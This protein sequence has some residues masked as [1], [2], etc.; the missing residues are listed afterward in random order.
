MGKI[1]CFGVSTLDTLVPISHADWVAKNFPS[2]TTGLSSQQIVGGD[3]T[4][5]A[6]V[7]AGL[8]MPVKH[9][10]IVGDDSSGRIIQQHL[11]Q[12]AGLESHLLVDNEGDSVSP[13]IYVR[14]GTGDRHIQKKP[15]KLTVSPDQ[16]DMSIL[17]D[18]S[19]LYLDG[20]YCE[21]AL[22]LAT[23]AKARGILVVVEEDTFGRQ[24][25]KELIALA[26]IVFVS[27]DFLIK[28]KAWLDE[29]LEA[30]G[31]E[32]SGHPVASELAALANV[33][34]A[35]QAIFTTLGP[36]G[37]ILYSPGHGFSRQPG[38][39]VDNLV[40][41]TG[42]GDTFM[43]GFLF[44][45]QHRWD[46]ELTML[47]ANHL[48]AEK[49]KHSGAEPSSF[50]D[51]KELYEWLQQRSEEKSR[52]QKEIQALGEEWRFEDNRDYGNRLL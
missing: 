23:E 32:S 31:I 43:A 50:V 21:L 26:N 35:K 1:L 16:L 33:G 47:F 6:K 52:W 42:A 34:C 48:A 13:M 9:V 39:S 12:R 15:R 45:T 24:G 2:A 37:A 8:G 17:E 36:E 28:G 22:A 5:T 10:S 49:C 38:E 44:G 40:D 11:A 27:S 41:T 3:A 19:I 7:L 29:Q 20:R 30:D 25:D 46:Y 4:N 18:V 14:K 51:Q